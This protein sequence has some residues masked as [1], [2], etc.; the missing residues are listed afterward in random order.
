MIAKRYIDIALFMV[1]LLFA[2]TLM[3]VGP[4]IESKLLPVVEDMV[5]DDNNFSKDYITGRIK[6]QGTFYKGRDE[7]LPVEVS[8]WEEIRGI[9]LPLIVDFSQ[10]TFSSS[11][12]EVLN[13]RPDGVVQYG[14]W[15]IDNYL[16]KG[17]LV[18][19]TL[20]SCHILWHTPTEVIVLSK[21]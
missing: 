15:V 20:H 13:S 12:P 3:I 19:N 4:S 16:D 14:P 21:D 8:F 11:D 1:A 7:C 6:I 9:K 10:D 18:M 5:V 17:D 2:S